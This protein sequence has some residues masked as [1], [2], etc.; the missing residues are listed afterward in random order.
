MTTPVRD[1]SMDQ[2]LK[3]VEDLWDSIAADQEQLPLTPE[4]RTELDARLDELELDGEV[5]EPAAEVLAKL[6]KSL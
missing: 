2:R 6:R 5:G 3:L 4:Q 1:L